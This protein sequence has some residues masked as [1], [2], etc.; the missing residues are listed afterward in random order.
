MRI[1][2]KR[3]KLIRNWISPD[4]ILSRDL[5]NK[6]NYEKVTFLFTGWLVRAKGVLDLI[7]SFKRSEILKNSNLII[8]GDGHLMNEIKTT[9]KK[10]S[11]LNISLLGWC[12]PREINKLLLSSNV[13]VLPT[14]SEG[15]PNS[16]LEALAKGLPVISTP[17]GGIPDS[18]INFHNGFLFKSGDVDMLQKRMEWFVL[19][20]D[21]F[22]KY[23][24]NSL[25]MAKRNHNYY[26][27]CKKL[28]NVFS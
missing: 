5:I 26:N 19:N 3:I 17:V 2:K 24:Y 11:L 9:I 23:S 12:K 27:N 18:V 22:S 16:I 10:Y 25:D 4:K 13:F 14:Y 1:N 6:Q 8:A 20:K 28:F 15:F 7:E 21:N